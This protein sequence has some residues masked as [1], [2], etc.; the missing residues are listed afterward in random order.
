REL[1]GSMTGDQDDFDLLECGLHAL[2]KLDAVHNREPEIGDQN[3]DVVIHDLVQSSLT[4]VGLPRF[5]SSALQHFDHCSAILDV[6]FNYEDV[7]AFAN[8]KGNSVVNV[9]P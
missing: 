6:V 3:V 9:V 8:H 5:V 1:N 4:I 2:Q 7:G